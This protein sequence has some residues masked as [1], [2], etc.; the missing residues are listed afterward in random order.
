MQ[1]P[2]VM[3]ASLPPL[4]SFLRSLTTSKMKPHTHTTEEG[5]IVR[6]YHKSKA[7]F[8]SAGFWL[9]LTMGF[10]LEHFLWQKLWPFTIITNLL[11]LNH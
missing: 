10:P 6:C 8:L 4:R 2:E 9:G 7:T 3:A 5:L 11:G 1:P